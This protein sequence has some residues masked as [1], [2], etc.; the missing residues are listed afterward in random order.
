MDCLL[1]GPNGYVS[2]NIVSLYKN[3]RFSGFTR[4][5]SIDSLSSLIDTA[6]CIFHT[7]SKQKLENINDDFESNFDLTK[8]IVDHCNDKRLI[9]FSSIHANS[10]SDFG[11]VKKREEE[12]IQRNCSSYQILQLPHTFGLFGRPN[13]NSVFNT[14]IYLI[15]NGLDITVNTTNKIFNLFPIS[16]LNSYIDFSHG[17][18]FVDDFETIPKTLVDFVHDVYDVKHSNLVLDTAYETH[19]L[20]ALNYYK[21]D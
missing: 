6:D 8:Y 7:A 10:D 3:A 9:Y 1:T 20:S 11:K 18:S 19:I 12:Y 2:R 5:M 21:N 15:S 13:Y 17:C 16:T 14:F 4:N